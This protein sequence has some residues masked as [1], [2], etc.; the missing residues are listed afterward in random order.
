MIDLI[1]ISPTEANEGVGN[2]LLPVYSSDECA[3]MPSL[4]SSLT[5]IEQKQNKPFQSIFSRQPRRA[6]I[7]LVIF[8]FVRSA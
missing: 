3:I 7:F 8:V 4:Y 1:D 6:E 2:Y 5:E